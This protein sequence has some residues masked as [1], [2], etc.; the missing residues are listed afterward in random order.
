MILLWIA[1]IGVLPDSEQTPGAAAAPSSSRAQLTD[2]ERLDR[3]K[4]IHGGAGPWAVVGYRIG[5]RALRDLDLPRQSFALLVVHR[6][7]AEVQY[8]CV[9]DGLQ[10]ATGAS[11]GK[12]NLKLETVEAEQ[13]ETV[14]EDRRSGRRLRFRIKPALADTILNIPMAGNEAAGARVIKLQDEQIFTVEELPKGTERDTREPHPAVG[15]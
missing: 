15:K 14:V 10:A 9:A 12:L 2:A 1:L 4:A 7:P 3:V 11:A 5:E 6:S 13:L 8:S